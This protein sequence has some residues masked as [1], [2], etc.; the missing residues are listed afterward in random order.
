MTAVTAVITNASA[1]RMSQLMARRCR[2]GR[3]S[4]FPMCATEPTGP[5]LVPILL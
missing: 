3:Y 5:G 1:R 4:A 2:E